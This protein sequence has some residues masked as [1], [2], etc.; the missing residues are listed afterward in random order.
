MTVM[1]SNPKMVQGGGSGGGTGL[2]PQAFAQSSQEQ[3]PEPS[4]KPSVQLYVRLFMG[5]KPE[6]GESRK[7]RNKNVL[8]GVLLLRK[9][10]VTIVIYKIIYLR[11][12]E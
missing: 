4:S 3:G 11:I 1:A 9:H 10:K 6:T 7:K 5:V 8:Y 2:G 12:L